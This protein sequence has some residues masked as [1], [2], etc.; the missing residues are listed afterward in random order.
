MV[1]LNKSGHVKATS[2]TGHDLLIKCVERV[3]SRLW[4]GDEV[5]NLAEFI[6]GESVLILNSRI[7]KK[8]IRNI[9]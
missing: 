4:I 9:L 5:M 8:K 2:L 7:R 1:D 3:K 6:W